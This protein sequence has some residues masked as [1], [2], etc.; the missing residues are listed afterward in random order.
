VGDLQL[1]PA[2]Q[3]WVNVVLLWIG[4]GT[5]AG[6]A[7]RLLVPGR[8]PGVVGTLVIGMVGSTL[9][10]LAL[11]TLLRIDNFNPIGPLGFLAAAGGAV[12]LLIGYRLGALLRPPEGEP[13]N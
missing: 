3:Q 4:F 8:Q 6:L 11:V 10:P 7:A 5:L 12:V 1:A 13:E 9:G 2:A